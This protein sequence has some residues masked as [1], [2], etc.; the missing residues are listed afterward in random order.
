[1]KWLT[2]VDEF[3]HE[4]LCLEVE[5]NMTS[6]TVINYLHDLFLTRGLPRHIR[7]DNGPEF[8]ATAI[9]RWL[10]RLDVNVLYIEPGS[11]WENAYAESFNSHFRDEFLALEILDKLVS[12]KRLTSS[13]RANYNDHRPHSPLG[14]QTPGEF[15]RGLSALFATLPRRK[16]PGKTPA[17]EANF[18]QPVLS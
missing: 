9:R 4:N 17:V 6:E 5:H 12:A 18:N 16:A 15:A 2:I 8:M 14:Y 10:A 3:T 11:P 7:S 1:L 13:W